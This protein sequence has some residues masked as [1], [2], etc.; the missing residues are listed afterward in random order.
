MPLDATRPLTAL[1]EQATQLW[2]LAPHLDSL[3]PD[4]NRRQM[5]HA[6]AV[7]SSPAAEPSLATVEPRSVHC[8]PVPAYWMQHHS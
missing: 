1:N 5:T 6:L 4:S 2:N 7:A 8:S 3:H